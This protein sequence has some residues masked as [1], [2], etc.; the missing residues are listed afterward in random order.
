MEGLLE[1]LLLLVGVLI[2]MVV[3]VK[4][5]IRKVNAPPANL[6]PPDEGESWL[7]KNDLITNPACSSIPGNI[8]HHEWH[9]DD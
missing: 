2:W 4:A 7:S 9:N 6:A 1:G 8:F 5:E 3:A